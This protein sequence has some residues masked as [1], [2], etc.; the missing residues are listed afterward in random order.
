MNH[1]ELLAHGELFDA[2]AYA[3]N[4]DLPI[5]RSWRRGDGHYRTSGIAIRLGDGPATPLLEQERIAIEFLSRHRQALIALGKR[6]GVDFFVL[7]F[8][9]RIRP[10]EGLVGF[11]VGPSRR[12]MEHA[13]EVGVEPIFY[14]TLDKPVEAS[15]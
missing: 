15:N 8:D 7:G 10:E 9:M 5:D 11:C 3:K 2:D 14:V 12:L 4:S 13:L 1:F 6:R